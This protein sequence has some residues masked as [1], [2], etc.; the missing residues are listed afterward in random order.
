MTDLKIK[1]EENFLKKKNSWNLKI[2]EVNKTVEM[3]KGKTGKP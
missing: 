1:E 2:Q 3:H